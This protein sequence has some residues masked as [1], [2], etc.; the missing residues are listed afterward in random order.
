M[1]NKPLENKGGKRQWSAPVT[2]CRGGP[3]PKGLIHKNQSLLTPNRFEVLST[4]D[5]DEELGAE[6]TDEAQVRAG[7]ARCKPTNRSQMRRVARPHQESYFLAG[8]V[9][10]KTTRFLL[11]TG[12]TTNLLSKSTYDKLSEKVKGNL[13]PADRIQGMVA[14][15]SPLRFFGT[16]KLSCRIKS[17]VWEE[18]FLVAQMRQ[19]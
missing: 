7:V 6:S 17:L 18:R 15:G 13:E 5:I 1:P 8:K 12:C 19:Y 10:G 9:A 2:P 16:I 11:D 4:D 3:N 14:D